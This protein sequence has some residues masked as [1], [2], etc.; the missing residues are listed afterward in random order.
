MEMPRKASL[1]FIL[2]T[3]FVDVIGW[4]LIIPVMPDLIAG[5]KHIPVNIASAYGGWL[6]FAYAVMQ[7][8]FAPV[9]GN[10]SDKYGRRPVLLFSLL[11]FAVDYLFLALAPSYG[12]FFVG[13]IIAGITGASF[14]TASAYIA[15]IST[16][17]DR[18]KNFGM[19]GAAFGL[20]F[21]IGPAIG[22]MLSG[23]GIRAPFY[24]AAG[25]CFV[26]FLYGYF[27]LPESLDKEHRR[28]FEWRRANPIG[29]LL[30]IKKYPAIAGLM[31]ALFFVYLAAHAVQSNWSYFTEFRFS[32]SHK[33]IGYSLALAGLL[34]ASVQA[35]LVRIV[36]PKLGNEKSVYIGL[37]FYSFGLFLFAFASQ[38]WMM[39]AFLVPY[40]LGGIAG[41]ALQAIMTGN[42]PRN[43]QGE[44]QGA[45]TS[46]MSITTIIG[47]LVMNNLF[48]WFTKQ[49]A[50]LY[51]PGAPFFLGGLLILL[52]TYLA[53]V[54][55]RKG[56]HVAVEM[57]RKDVADS[58]PEA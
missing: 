33:M 28:P 38:S 3:V 39:F 42:V 45:L 5:M 40:C 20:G 8:I 47:P 32:W 43:E 30:Q 9:L 29:T 41:P 58:R 18:A 52:S 17:E 7:F 21:I 50:A 10:L 19:V 46:M 2:I 22:G 13:R 1:G 26:N 14:T 34:V 24:A 53:Y 11:G 37:L 23:F 35:G 55:L 57:V 6:L 44:L 49:S 31:I 54:S 27:I 56:H 48:T 16:P 12:W 4:G 15:D 25:L 36:N 51:F